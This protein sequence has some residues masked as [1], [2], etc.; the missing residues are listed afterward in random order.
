MTDDD[1]QRII[2][3]EGSGEGV[4]VRHRG[5]I[6]SVINNAKCIIDM[7]PEI[8]FGD[9]IWSF[10]GDRPILNNWTTLTEMPSKTTE[11]EAMSKDLKKRGFRFV[12][13]TTCYS[14]MQS[15]GLVIDHIADSPEWNAAKKRLEVRPGGYKRGDG[16]SVGE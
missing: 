2:S 13:P 14:L 11:S 8:S 9:H 6:E 5:K 3:T 10:V 16:Q 15:C 1:V 7:R 12:G 4:V